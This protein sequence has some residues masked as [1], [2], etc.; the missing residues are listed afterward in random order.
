[1]TTYQNRYRELLRCTRQW[2]NLKARKWNGFGQNDNREPGP[3][4]LTMTC[5]AC[6]QP[7]L[8]LPEDWKTHEGDT[9][10]IMPSFVMDGNFKVEHM[11][12]QKPLDDVTIADGHG[13]MVGE[14]R[15]KE[16]I[17]IVKEVKLVCS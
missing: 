1:L 14:E 2:R 16:H 15:Y 10:S 8:N 4:Q 3:G 9:G 17:R 7:G 5:P 11:K 12:M 13:F 6:P